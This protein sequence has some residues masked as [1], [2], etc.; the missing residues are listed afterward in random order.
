MYLQYLSRDYILKFDTIL[1]ELFPFKPYLD[2]RRFLELKHPT[3][4]SRQNRSCYRGS[5]VKCYVVKD[6]WICFK[7]N[8]YVV[9]VGGLGGTV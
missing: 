5:S 8:S 7:D 1:V 4:P 6:T 3:V 9:A 2:Q